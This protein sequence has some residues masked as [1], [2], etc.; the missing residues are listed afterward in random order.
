MDTGLPAYSTVEARLSA[1]VVALSLTVNTAFIVVTQLI[2]LQL[3]RRIRRSS[4]LAMTGL[5]FAA[6]WAVF[7]LAALPIP[8]AARITCV[9]TFA[10]LFGLGE[11]FLAPTMA[12]LVNI[13]ADERVR[14][15]ANSLSGMANSA[16]L[17]ASP[18]IVRD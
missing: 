7:G 17:I 1:H 6:S 13:L 15:R 16:A 2:V 18:A 14:G 3:V 12:P 4:A 10:G 8:P 11:T 9:L 5:I